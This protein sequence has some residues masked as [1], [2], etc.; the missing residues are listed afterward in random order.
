MYN[1]YPYTDFSELN[2][3]WFLSEFKQLK[4]DW[5]TTSGQWDQM[6]LDFQTLE[7]TVQTFTTFV[8]NYF[9]NL[10]VQDEINTKLDQMAQDGTLT[11]LLAP[12]VDD[13][14]P[15]VVDD[16][17]GA[18][19]TDQLPGVVSDQLPGVVEDQ[20]DAAVAPEVPGAVTDWLNDNVDP[21]GSAVVVDSTFSITG[22]AADAG[23]AGA[24]FYDLDNTTEL[25][26]EHIHQTSVNLFD[27]SLQTADTIDPHYYYNGEPYSDPQYDTQY[28]CTAPIYLKPS[29]KYT[30]GYIPAYNTY[31]VPWNGSSQGLFYYDKD[32]N[33]LGRTNNATFTTPAN[34]VYVRFNFILY[35]GLVNTLNAL[36]NQCIIV[37]GDTLPESYVAYESTWIDEYLNEVVPDIYSKFPIN[38]IIDADGNGVK[39]ISK[40]DNHNDI[41]VYFKKKGG[42]DLPDFS[43]ISLIPNESKKI[44]FDTS[45]AVTII[46]GSSDW[47]APF[48]VKAKSNIDGDLPN[49]QDFTGGNHQYNNQGSGSTPTARCT[50]LV[51]KADNYNVTSG[52]DRCQRF[53]IRW[54]NLVQATNTKKADGTGREVLQEKHRLIFDGVRFEAYVDLIPLEDLTINTWYGYQWFTNVYNYVR[55]I[56]ATNRGEYDASNVNSSSG[57]DDSCHVISYDSSGNCLTLDLDAD[58]DLGDHKYYNSNKSMFT[59]TY[60]KGYCNIIE[61]TD[62]Y[63]D[64]MYS[65]HGWYTFRKM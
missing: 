51:F 64:D 45:G 54:T 38:Y 61:N 58:Y 46:S 26:E 29:T 65:L 39:L 28:N 10:D 14:L 6:Q 4:E 52:S 16:K 48:I 62:V 35:N 30:I 9:E 53:E 50:S 12:L 32:D 55:Y 63:Q 34:C 37:E 5:E 47:F 3:D 21:V 20:I 40:Y 11:D 31:T 56:G 33:Y 49:S 59:L 13:K 19:V 57:D 41:M 8:E 60:G 24:R 2:L 42:N 1:K 36:H 7:G 15:G 43:S 17:L 25:I 22:A 27:G 23:A 18:V 44:T